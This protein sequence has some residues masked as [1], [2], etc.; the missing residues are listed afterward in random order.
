MLPRP[1]LPVAVREHAR[2]GSDVEKAGLRR[3]QRG[4]RARFSPRVQ[5]HPMAP[6]PA[7]SGTNSSMSL[8]AGSS[9]RIDAKL[10]VA[11]GDGEIDVTSPRDSRDRSARR[12]TAVVPASAIEI[13]HVANAP[14]RLH[15]DVAR[16]QCQREILDFFEVDV[17]LA[18]DSHAAS[19]LPGMPGSASTCV[20]GGVRE[21][22]CIASVQL[23]CGNP[24]RATGLPAC[25]APHTK[26]PRPT[27]ATIAIATAARRTAASAAPRRAATQGKSPPENRASRRRATS[28]AAAQAQC[29]RPSTATR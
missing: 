28:A 16:V 14:K 7:G 5:S 2:A 20:S 18:C 24:I 4:K 19:V 22:H 3:R 17:A 11:I 1:R 26:T 25:S 15:S 8:R 10:L 6:L 21:I 13:A 29:R 23:S 27:A 12:A 9:K